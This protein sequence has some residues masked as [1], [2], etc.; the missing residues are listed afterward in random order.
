MLLKELTIHYAHIELKR[1]KNGKTYFW[2]S[3]RETGITY[4]AFPERVKGWYE[5]EAK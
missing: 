2:I 1:D 4:F 3:D 5:L